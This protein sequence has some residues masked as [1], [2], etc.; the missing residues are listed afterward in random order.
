MTQNKVTCLKNGQKSWFSQGFRKISDFKMYRVFSRKK[1][2]C[3]DFGRPDLRWKLSVV[4]GEFFRLLN[5]PNPRPKLHLSL[6]EQ[7]S[8]AFPSFD[9]AHFKVTVNTKTI[10]VRVLGV[11]DSNPDDVPLGECAILYPFRQGAN[12]LW[13]GNTKRDS[14]QKLKNAKIST[15]FSIFGIR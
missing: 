5:N 10:K 11:S 15:N 4:Y 2:A 9:E 12:A 7:N 13:T 8:T 3:T 1:R 6:C 14:Y